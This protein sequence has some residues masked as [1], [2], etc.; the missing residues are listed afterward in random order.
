M[1]TPMSSTHRSDRTRERATAAR[2]FAVALSLSD[3]LPAAVRADVAHLLLTLWTADAYTA[4]RE[5]LAGL[6]EGTEA[7]TA[8]PGQ[9]R[10]AV[11]R[12][13]VRAVADAG[14][15]RGAVYQ[16]D[17]L[18]RDL[19]HAWLGRDAD[20]PEMLLLRQAHRTITERRHALEVAAVDAVDTT[21]APNATTEATS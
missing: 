16:L 3:D 18:L 9:A 17:R 15:H 10:I 14:H 2:S 11:A 19:R 13:M 8:E 4:A 12:R 21:T 7:P 20:A 5:I 6:T 1:S